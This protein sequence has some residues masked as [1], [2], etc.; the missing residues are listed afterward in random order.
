M[1]ASAYGIKNLKY[2]L[3]NLSQWTKEE[4]DQNQN[5]DEMYTHLIEQ[6]RK[7][8]GHVTAN[9]GGV[10]ETIKTSVQGGAVYEVTP[11]NTQREAAAFLQNQ[12]FLTPTWLIDKNIWNRINNPG[13]SDPVASTQE[14]VLNNL[15]SSE[16]LSRLQAST[17]RFGASKAFS[18]LELLTDVQNGLFSELISKKTIDSYR[19]TLQRSYVDKLSSLINPASGGGFTIISF[20]RLSSL[21]S[22]DLSNTDIPSIARAQLLLLKTQVTRAILT[23]TDT[24][25]RIHLADLLQRIKE[26]IDSK[27]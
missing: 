26:A 10:S 23:T 12:L 24:M 18:A 22:T 5:I 3:K 1:K 25:S 14:T 8:M 20:S 21:S 6:F 17:E 19:R 4:T 11:K 13:D 9:I 27:K 16:R 7:Y 15:I 2:I